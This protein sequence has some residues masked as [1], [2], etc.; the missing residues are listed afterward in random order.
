MQSQ[1]IYGFR[2]CN[3]T[4]ATTNLHAT[5]CADFSPRAET[6]NALS[7]LYRETR[8]AR[9]R[10]SNG[11]RQLED[12][13]IKYPLMRAAVLKIRNAAWELGDAILLE[14]GPPSSNGKNDGSLQKLKEAQDILFKEEHFEIELNTLLRY[15]EIAYKFPKDKRRNVS[16]SNHCDAGS[17]EILDNIIAAVGGEENVTRAI[18][19]EQKSQDNILKKEKAKKVMSHSRKEDVRT[20][21]GELGL[22][23]LIANAKGAAKKARKMLENGKVHHLSEN[24]AL[25]LAEE[26][27]E[28]QS[29]WREIL[30]L[31]RS[32]KNIRK[33]E[34]HI[35]VIENDDK[36]KTIVALKKRL[37]N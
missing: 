32:C 3:T 20:A 29:N 7:L 17:P 4:L 10:A 35:S 24:T 19:R 26:A 5:K 15:R 6:V 21:T 18:I 31:L 28:L 11:E 12:K 33:S 36:T 25:V 16:W 22:E 9:A 8:L 2:L 1:N 30:M 27:S 13:K 23:V 34:K 14:C 37:L